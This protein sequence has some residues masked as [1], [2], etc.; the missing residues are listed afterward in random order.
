MA[1]V[2]SLTL[3]ACGSDSSSGSGD[4]GCL[5]NRAFF[6][7][8]VWSAFMGAKCVLCHTDG[9]QAI[10]KGAQFHLETASYP[11]F[12]DANL[13]NIDKISKKIDFTTKQ[14][15]LLLK[16]LGKLNH[17]G[18]VQL[19]ED[20]DEYQNL[21]ELVTR[22]Q[23]GEDS[24]A[25]STGKT[26]ADVKMLDPGSTLRKAALDVA[27]RLPTKTETDKVTAGG[28][29]AIDG[30]LDSMMTEEIF[31]TRVREIWN[32]LLLTN[33]YA[34]GDNALRFMNMDL[35][36]KVGL[37]EGDDSTA[38]DEDRDAANLALAQEPLNLIT[39]IVKNNKPFTD[40]AAADYTVVN[41]WLAKVYD[42]N[43]SFKNNKDPN[44]WHEAKVTLQTGVAV[45]HAGILSTP[46]FL[47]R[48]QTTPTN[49]NR[50]RARRVYLYLLATDILQ[51][52][53][54]PVDATK[55][56][57]VDD[58][59]E[60]SPICVACHAHM[61]PIAGGFRG[62]D[63]QDYELFDPK[64]DNATIWHPDMAQSGF[65]GTP[66]PA[67]DYTKAL[68]WLGSQVAK[69]S[70]FA[71]NAV[72][73]TFKGL[74]GQDPLLYPPDETAPTFKD[75]L[76][77]W[78]AQDDFF[79]TTGSAFVSGNY[80]LKVVFKAIIK[81][82]Y[83]RGIS[84][85]K[86]AHAALL[87]G[88][89]TGRMLTP[90]MLSRKLNA[91]MGFPWISNYD[92]TRDYLNQDFYI[93]YG[94]IDSD[95]VITRLTTPN[96]LLYAVQQRMANEVACHATAFDFTKPKDQR[97][98]FPKVDVAEQPESAGHAVGGSVSDIKDN[99]VYLFDLILGQKVSKTDAEVER[100]YQL[101]LD[102]YHEVQASGDGGLIGECQGNADPL[103]GAPV[104]DASKITSDA[105][106][107]IR[108]W[109][110]VITYLLSDY[111]FLYE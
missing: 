74:T 84:A 24:C 42:V 37:Y 99:I 35:Y 39:Y 89:G 12:V 33:K 59:T 71:V 26:I 68:P 82:P 4:D 10:V 110:A 32:D 76:A 7:Q 78:T 81:S 101:Y 106:F 83:Y 48:W 56:A 2:A 90:E 21:K 18:G 92:R 72:R 65:E 23:S 27:G 109:Q 55:V 64:S 86:D 85:P 14:S 31:Y 40:I 66:M 9:G 105:N 94:G 95:S 30:I 73:S 36:P 80:N 91:I 25:D 53:T 8:K 50:A 29:A 28:D 97:N 103:T 45:P 38:S 100:T 98:L 54:R 11:A 67:G 15:Y 1:A 108:P 5:S 17:G 16:P 22:V 87:A 60:N 34:G 88:I 44:E 70:R 96:G 19:T 52:A 111:S 102:T 75:D 13:D 79:R 46:V 49:R 104:P 61:D 47:N 63:E 77:A 62:Y 20:S 69:D 93:T 51:L 3:G 6:E 58:P 57:A 43:V 41:P 107:T